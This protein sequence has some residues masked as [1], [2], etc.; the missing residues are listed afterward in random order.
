[1]SEYNWTWIHRRMLN[2]RIRTEAFRDAIE[3]VVKPG[4][5]VVD[6]GAGTGILSLFAARAGAARV[7]AIERSPTIEQAKAIARANGLEGRIEFVCADSSKAELPEKVDVI[8]SECLGNGGVEEDML[9]SVLSVRDRYLKPGGVMIP[10]AMTA[11][12]A[13]IESAEAF[14][15]I[16][17]F[18]TDVYGFD[19]AP[20]RAK[21]INETHLTR[22]TP[23]QMLANAEVVATFDTQTVREPYYQTSS[24]FRLVRDGRLHGLAGWFDSLIAEGVKIQTGPDSPRTHWYHI[25]YPIPVADVRKAELVRTEIA[26]T[27]GANN[28][29]WRWKVEVFRGKRALKTNS[30]RAAFEHTNDGQD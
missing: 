15:F 20:M 29:V 21:A 28:I 14:S 26:A 10:A 3:K 17:D 7:Y 25:Y 12:L 22:F 11:F 27:P 16:D 4:D 18:N 24:V 9:P 30:P 1:M 5:V 13:P 2:D 19:Y 8:V 23:E 6:V